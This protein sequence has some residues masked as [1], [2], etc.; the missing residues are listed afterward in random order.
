[1]RPVLLAA[2]IALFGGL[3]PIE[4]LTRSADACAFCG[5]F[6][7]GYGPYSA[8]YGGGAYGAGYRGY[9]PTTYTAGYGPT[10]SGGYYGPLGMG[11]VGPAARERRMARR[12]YRRG[13]WGGMF[14]APYAAGYGSY[15]GVAPATYSA[16]YAPA[17]PSY[18][19][20]SSCGTAAPTIV[21]SPVYSAPI[22]VPDACGCSTPQPD[23]GCPGPCDCG[24]SP[25]YSTVVP[26][27]S[28][29]P[30]GNCGAGYTP[31]QSLSPI[32]ADSSA[33][34]YE[35]GATYDDITP[36]EFST[37]TYGSP[38]YES[39]IYGD[40]YPSGDVGTPADP[41]GP[42]QLP[43]DAINAT[44]W[45]TVPADPPADDDAMSSPGDRNPTFEN[46]DG[47]GAFRS[48]P[49]S[50]QPEPTWDRPPTEDPGF[51]DPMTR[52]DPGY[53]DR[54]LPGGIDPDN[55]YD[56]GGSGEE[57]EFDRPIT[58][59][60]P[61]DRTPRAAAPR[62]MHDVASR[63]VGSGLTIARSR[64]QVRSRHSLPSRVAR[65]YDLERGEYGPASARMASRP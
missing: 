9:G 32:P 28:S 58:P 31:S 34:I 40:S 33:P 43:P 63:S 44:P 21:N 11:I 14:G 53:D 42:P 27:P 54:T 5:G 50:Q 2:V 60:E 7:S 64:T 10:A 26:A 65:R 61:K 15:G 30:N 51:R 17:I 13:W 48:N 24:S 55:G 56:P 37:P 8:R 59:V 22:A 49:G 25:A 29:C 36:T 23:C 20:C 52:P 47:D 18:G 19:G 62:A 16:G 1:M 35:G 6:F 3:T 41:Y 45:R 46:G 4:G 57:F 38:T 39:P 12:A